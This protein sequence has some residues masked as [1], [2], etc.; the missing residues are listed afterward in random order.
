MIAWA[1]MERL[2]KNYKYNNNINLFDLPI[3]FE[4]IGI[5]VNVKEVT[6]RRADIICPF[7]KKHEILGN[8][9]VFEIQFSKQ[10]QSTKDSRELDWAIRGYSVA[11]LFQNDFEYISELLIETKKPEINVDSFANLI[12]QNKKI[13]MRELKYCIQEECRKLDEKKDS[14]IKEISDFYEFTQSKISQIAAPQIDTIVK[15]EFDKLKGSIQPIC[16]KCK[17]PFILKTNQQNGD[18]FWACC[19]YPKCKITMPYI[20]N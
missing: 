4:K 12:K 17:I 15:K 13:Y 14:L 10:R 5:E 8:G 19:N 1:G 11:W 16:P 3:D 7:K 2:L 20:D 9:I 6:L 18:N